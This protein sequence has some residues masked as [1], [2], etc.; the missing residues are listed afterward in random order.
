VSKW[1]VDLEKLIEIQAIIT[2]AKGEYIYLG[3]AKVPE[4]VDD[5]EKFEKIFECKMP[6]KLFVATMKK[7]NELIRKREL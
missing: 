3:L 2:R 5:P 6:R 4:G 1:V 7:L